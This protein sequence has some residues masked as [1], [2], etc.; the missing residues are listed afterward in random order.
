MVQVVIE[1]SSMRVTLDIRRV[2]LRGSPRIL[3][4]I[5]EE[6][7]GRTV[8]VPPQPPSLFFDTLEIL[9]QDMLESGRDSGACPAV[10]LSPDE[11]PTAL[12]KK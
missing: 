4:D 1:A 3:C 12:I 7:V 2:Y 11:T 10:K 9:L 6:A 5:T 8:A